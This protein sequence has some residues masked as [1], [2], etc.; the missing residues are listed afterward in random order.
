MDTL[1]GTG[2]IRRLLVTMPPRH[3]KSEFCSKCLPAWYL[4]TFPDRR[5]ILTSY[6]AGFA[7]EWGRKSRELLELNG[8]RV[9]GVKVRSDSRA[10]DRWNIWGHEGGMATAGRG[11]SVTG[12]GADLLLVDDP[13]KNAE[14]AASET[15]RESL[16]EWYLS[17]AHTRLEPDGAIIVVQT[18]WNEKDLAGR[19]RA[20]ETNE[21]WRFANFPAI[22]EEGD[23][24]GRKP[25]EAL[26][27]ERWP[28]DVLTAKRD[29]VRAYWWASLYQQ[30]PAPREGGMFRRAKVKIQKA[31]PRNMR[32]LVRAWDKGGTEGGG[33]PTAGVL[34]GELDGIYYVCDVTRGQWSHG[35]RDDN[36]DL[37]ASLDVT[38]WGEK[39][40]IALEQEPGS[41]GKQ[42]A[43]ISVRRLAGYR[44]TAERAS[45]SKEIRA[46]QFASQW[47]AGNVVLIE[48][49]WNADYLDELCSFP[50]GANDDQV[51]ASSLAFNKLANR[52]QF[53]VAGV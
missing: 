10:A 47:D 15:I 9:F 37:T 2:G 22:A 5:I 23:L 1:T 7:A 45:G 21:R 44:V 17:T 51:D 8:Q 14:E 49:P 38:A 27:P 13:I 41:G 20:G 3:G 25:G 35:Q 50:N 11:G 52:K 43:E 12:K 36:I 33:D 53:F 30:R 32:A 29:A 26:W 19:I 40:R 16:W 18:C 6:E 31:A 46:D 42:S 24:L 48:G 28:L 39:V 34:M 4:G